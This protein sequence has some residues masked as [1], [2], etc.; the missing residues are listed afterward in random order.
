[1]KTNL[2]IITIL[3]MG[4]ISACK[5][6]SNTSDNSDSQTKSTS[7]EIFSAGDLA[8]KYVAS[9]DSLNEYKDKEITVKGFSYVS[10]INDEDKN[11]LFLSDSPDQEG[12]SFSCQIDLDDPSQAEKFDKLKKGTFYNLT[13]KGKYFAKGLRPCQIINAEEVP[14]AN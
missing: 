5:S 1:M 3:F 8:R 11:Q 7:N 6:T 12:D 13:V 9:P 14:A 10:T 4:L 2:V